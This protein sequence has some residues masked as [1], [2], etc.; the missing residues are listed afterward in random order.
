MDCILSESGLSSAVAKCMQK[1]TYL[2]PKPSVLKPQPGS[3]VFTQ[4]AINKFVNIAAL[5]PG[6]EQGTGEFGLEVVLHALHNIAQPRAPLLYKICVRNKQLNA[7]L[8]EAKED[9]L[10][11]FEGA[12]YPTNKGGDRPLENTNAKGDCINLGSKKYVLASNMANILKSVKNPDCL[13]LLINF[14]VMAPEDKKGVMGRIP[15][16]CATHQ[17]VDA[18]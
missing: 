7:T 16:G 12:V 4:N 17:L 6:Q 9:R 14:E 3:F 10:L 2:K 1:N 8:Y 18:K 11:F 13:V 5:E 15:C